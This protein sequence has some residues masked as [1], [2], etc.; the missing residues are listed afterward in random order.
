MRFFDTIR[1]DSRHAI[2]ILLQNPGFAIVA[3]LSLALG[4]GAN[5]AIFTLVNTVMLRSLPVRDPEQLVVFAR[6]PDQPEVGMSYPDYRYIRD[7]NRSF[8]GVIAYSGQSQAAMEVPDEGGRATPQLVTPTLVSGNY[9]DVLG[10]TP[11]AGRLFTPDDNVTEDAHPW[12]VLDYSFWRERFG[13]DSRVVGRR[14]TL[15]G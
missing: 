9:F 7:H 12:V 4:I 8:S 6:N 5:T 3:V 15:N 11:A 10:V 14:I 1:Q 13:G 2:R